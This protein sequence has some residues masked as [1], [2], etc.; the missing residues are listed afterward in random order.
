[1][2]MMRYRNKND[3]DFS[4]DYGESIRKDP[5]DV[6]DL[7]DLERG[8]YCYGGYAFMYTDHYEDGSGSGSGSG[9]CFYEGKG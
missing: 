9:S 1:M 2:G 7:F 4:S 3:I 5:S 6:V 8:D